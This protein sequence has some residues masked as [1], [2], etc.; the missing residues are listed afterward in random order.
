[1]F[2]FKSYQGETRD[3]Q[4]H[5]ISLLAICHKQLPEEI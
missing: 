5:T 4:W 3:S 2:Y 1:L